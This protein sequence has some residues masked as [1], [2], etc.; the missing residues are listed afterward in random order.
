MDNQDF[1]DMLKIIAALFAI[2]IIF[3]IFYSV[4]RPIID[5]EQIVSAR[6][7]F[8]D[9]KGVE[10]PITQKDIDYLA[11]IL[12][13]KKSI[14]NTDEKSRKFLFVA[15]MKNK[16][17]L[18]YE[19][20]LNGDKTVTCNRALANSNQKIPDELAEKIFDM[21]IFENFYISSKPTFPI[22]YSE[23]IELIPEYEINNWQYLNFNNKWKA[24]KP[25]H[26]KQKKDYT[27]KGNIVN[28]LFPSFPKSKKYKI[29][30][31]KNELIESGDIKNP[32]IKLPEKKGKYTI[33][34]IGFWDTKNNDSIPNIY[35]G[36]VKSR[37]SLSAYN[38]PD[39]I[40]PALPTDEYI[41]LTPIEDT[42][43]K[44]NSNY[45]IDYDKSTCKI[46]SFDSQKEVSI[47]I[48]NKN[49]NS[50][51][52]SKIF[53][54][55]IDNINAQR[56]VYIIDNKAYINAYTFAN[57]L[58]LY[59]KQKDKNTYSYLEN[60]YLYPIRLDLGRRYQDGYINKK[61]QWVVPAIFDS[62]DQFD[63]DYAQVVIY[64]DYFN[65]TPKVEGA[66]FEEFSKSF[67]EYSSKIY[68]HVY[69]AIIDKSG[70]ILNFP[71]NYSIDYQGNNIVKLEEEYY[72]D[73]LHYYLLDEKRNIKMKDIKNIDF[74]NNL[75]EGL[76]TFYTYSYT[77]D[78]NHF[79]SFWD[80]ENNVIVQTD[81]DKISPFS[82]GCS[83]VGYGDRYDLYPQLYKYGVIDKKGNLKIPCI[84]DNINNY[85][86]NTT[87]IC[88]I[89]KEIYQY[90][91]A[92]T[93]GNLLTDLDYKF[94]DS[95]KNSR[96]L[97]NIDDFT[98]SYIDKNFNLV[99]N[100][101]GEPISKISNY[102]N[103]VFGVYV[104]NK[105]NYTEKYSFSENYTIYPHKKDEEIK[106]DY[107]DTMGNTITHSYFDDAYPFKN[108]MAEVELDEDTNLS[109]YDT[110]YVDSLGRTID[111]QKY[112]YELE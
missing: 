79:A 70:K 6:L 48:L 112:E 53:I 39:D 40:E 42:L 44:L 33:E 14:H 10:I 2:F 74:A 85:S 47:N 22:I 96:A 57:D 56:S 84:F 21:D 108:G 68:K 87:C 75:S 9:E 58:G 4:S 94:A 99:K 109:Y 90:A 34:L 81:F 59:L 86:E 111:I 28:V 89:D 23:G 13:S 62:A 67:E 60:D 25:L 78:K 17:I 105:R 100:S 63:Q 72:N 82:N 66:N 43:K 19:I 65:H 71:E 107:I 76:A 54:I 88:F 106:F 102:D 1:Q 61:G 36:E 92:D 20:K 103:N 77:A 45:T 101:K 46:N 80:M 31:E 110:T 29:Y 27:I 12:N 37:I 24:L 16:S 49:V 7:Y 35:K 52:L 50:L 51:N 15:E 30:N 32:Q 38:S 95:F 64:D 18:K 69:S 41:L 73:S 3:V 104:E 8:E 11:I 91:Y 98:L 5:R 93:Q 26:T 97:V 83:V 55:N